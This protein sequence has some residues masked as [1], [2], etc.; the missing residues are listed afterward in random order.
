MTTM[1]SKICRY[2]QKGV[3][4]YVPKNGFFVKDCPECEKKKARGEVTGNE[5]GFIPSPRKGIP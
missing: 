4:T 3:P 1:P 5:P 2:H